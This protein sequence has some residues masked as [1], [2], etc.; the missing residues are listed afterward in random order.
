MQR[1]RLCGISDE[2]SG[3]V[4]KYSGECDQIIR[5]DHSVTGTDT[6]GGMEDVAPMEDIRAEAFRR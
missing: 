2:S 4:A 3:D 5:V 1:H 6:E